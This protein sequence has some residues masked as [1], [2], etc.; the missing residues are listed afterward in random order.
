M[1]QASYIIEGLLVTLQVFL[2]SLVLSVVLAIPI[3]AMRR[4]QNALLSFVAALISW[5]SRGIPPVVWLVIIYFGLSLGIISTVPVIGA[6]VGLGIVNSAYVADSIRAGLDA[7]NKGQWE[8]GEALAL[9]K[10]DVLLKVVL[11][12]AIPIMIASVTAYSITLLKNTAIASIIGA[13]ELVFY[14][15]NAVQ[16]GAEPLPSFLIIGCVYLVFTIPM[17]FLARGISARASKA[18]ARA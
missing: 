14:A 18:V 2:G 17:G 6:I 11:P 10:S 16:I 13:N 7:V 3:A 1:L 8:S 15:Y 4:S 9:K 12:Q 5:I